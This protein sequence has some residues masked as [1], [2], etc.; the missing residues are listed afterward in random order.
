MQHEPPH[1]PLQISYEKHINMQEV[2]KKACKRRGSF[3]SATV[4]PAAHFHN[5][6]KK[7]LLIVSFA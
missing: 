7:L 4:L 6:S 1:H 5:Y 3:S 2:V